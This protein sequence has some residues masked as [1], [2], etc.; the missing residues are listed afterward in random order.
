MAERVHCSALSLSSAAGGTRPTGAA[1]HSAQEIGWWG[2]FQCDER[3]KKDHNPG[4]SIKT[5]EKTRHTIVTD[6]MNEDLKNRAM[7]S[8]GAAASWCRRSCFQVEICS[9]GDDAC[10]ALII[11]HGLVLRFYSEKSPL[12]IMSFFQ[13]EERAHLSRLNGSS[14]GP[15]EGEEFW[16]LSENGD[17]LY[18]LEDVGLNSRQQRVKQ[19]IIAPHW[20]G[21]GK[22]KMWT[23]AKQRDTSHWHSGVKNSHRF[24]LLKTESDLKWSL[25]LF[26]PATFDSVC[27]RLNWS[28]DE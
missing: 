24:L 5:K 19:H 16:Q 18:E 8:R 15:A 23:G 12:N 9:T 22:K 10:I 7:S 25:H 2:F 13:P 3:E 21:F 27:G 26:R 17:C 20:G 4:K 14:N 28:A 6:G 11:Q 1:I